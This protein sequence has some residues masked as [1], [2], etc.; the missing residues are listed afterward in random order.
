MKIK[1]GDKF[2]CT[3]CENIQIIKKIKPGSIFIEL[4]LWFFFL[5][6]GLIYTIW[7]FASKKIVCQFCP[8]IELIP[9][10]CSRAQEIIKNRKRR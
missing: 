10:H 2:L 6:P 3:S 4:S 9:E 7:R 8:S 5:V 1:N